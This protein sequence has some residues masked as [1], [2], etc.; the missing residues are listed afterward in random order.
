MISILFCTYFALN[1]TQKF[2]A[3]LILLWLKFVLILAT[4]VCVHFKERGLLIFITQHVD[5]NF[6][7]SPYILH[8]IS[9]GLAFCLMAFETVK[10]D[11]KMRTN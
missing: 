3:A 4:T 7:F 1:F 5:P 6:Y 10:Q 11:V 2:K 8:S 9:N